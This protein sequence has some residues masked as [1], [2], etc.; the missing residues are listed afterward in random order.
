MSRDGWHPMVILSQ[1]KNISESEQR[2]CE[3]IVEGNYIFQFN[4]NSV[5]RNTNRT[6]AF[7]SLVS[8]K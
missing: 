6:S 7:G 4:K 3:I 8:A 2:G 5:M 1:F